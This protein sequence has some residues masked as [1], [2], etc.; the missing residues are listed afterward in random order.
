MYSTFSGCT[1]L[2]KAPE[3]P[4]SVTDM[5]FTFA[6]CSSLTGDLIINANPTNYGHCLSNV[7]TNPGCNLVLS[8][9]S[10]K[11][12]EIYNTK[13]ENSNITIGNQEIIM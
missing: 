10:T 1:S 3:I 4:N 6:D 7:A 12:Q 13:S 8:G 9:A 11:L 2:A 5:E